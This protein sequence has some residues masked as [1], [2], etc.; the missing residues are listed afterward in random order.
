LV[1][2]AAGS[3]TAP[4]Q[5]LK[6]SDISP[7]GSNFTFIGEINPGGRVK[8]LAIDPNHDN[9]LYAATEFS[10]V[11]K[12]TTGFVS[13]SDAS[14]GPSAMQWFQSSNGLRNGLTV[15]QYSLAVDQANSNR[16]LYATGDN[17]GRP[18]KADGT[19]RHGGLWVSTDAA[20]SWSHV[21]LCAAPFND[22]IS[23]VAFSTGRPFV[24]TF[25]GVWTNATSSL[26][27]SS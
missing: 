17:D 6:T 20:G 4:G 16:L 1:A 19:S 10:G 21:K 11:W 5:V 8:S 22:G 14:G 12:S 24:E 2:V 15:N 9:I 3:L 25:C 27:A 13:Q 18:P 23:S 7:D 26:D